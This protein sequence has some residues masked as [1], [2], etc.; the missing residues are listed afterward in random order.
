[1][2]LPVPETFNSHSSQIQTVLEFLKSDQNGLS[3]KAALARL[4]KVG[5]NELA[6][7][8]EIN[9]ARIF[10]RQFYSLMVGILVIAAVLSALF[11]HLIDAIVIAAII[12]VN[13]IMGFIQEYK[14]ERAIQALKKLVEPQVKVY[15]DGVIKV[16][17]PRDLVPGDV[18][19]LEEGDKIPADCRLLQVKNFQTMEASLTGE[20]TPLEKQ[21]EPVAATTSIAEQSN[22]VWMGTTVARGAAEAVVIKTGALTQFGQIATDLGSIDVAENHFEKKTR[23]LTKQMAVMALSLA[24]A[25]FVVGFFIRQFGLEEMLLYTIA[26]LVSALPEGLPIILVIVLA[27]GAQKMAQRNAIV[28]KLSATETLGVVSVIVTDKTGTLTQNKMAARAVA[29]PGSPVMVTDDLPENFTSFSA[30]KMV[31]I[32]SVCH[33]VRELAPASTT[34]S[35]KN[36]AE[37]T[38]LDLIGDP[39]EQA[40]Y[41]FAREFLSN[42]TGSSISVPH[43]LDDLPFVQELRLRASLVELASGKKEYFVVGAP[44]MLVRQCTQLLRDDETFDMTALERNHLSAQ[45]RQMTAKAMRVVALAYQ[46]VSKGVKSIDPDKLDDLI[47]VGFLGL[48]DPPR[49]DVAAAIASARSAGIQV[50]MATG[51]HPQ[52]AQAIAREIGLLGPEDSAKTAVITEAQISKMSDAELKKRLKQL[53]VFARLTPSSK[54]RLAKLLQSR[55]EVV[56]MTGDGVNDAPALKQANIGISMGV[57]GTDVAREASEIVLADDNFASIINAIEEGRTQFRNVRRTSC[58]LVVT[59][60]AQ[61]VA[62]LIA[63]FLGFPLPLLPL[64]ILWLNI[65]TGGVTDVALA[66]EPSHPDILKVPPRVTQENIL[67]RSMMPLLIGLSLVTIII[68]LSVF[69]LSLPHG[70]EYARTSTFVALSLVLLSM[71]FTMRSLHGSIRKVGI[72]ANKVV[73]FVFIFSLALLLIAVYFPPL[74]KVMRFVPLSP[75]VILSLAVWASGVFFLGELIKQIAPVQ[76]RYRRVR[77]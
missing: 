42:P 57:T 3:Q 24:A 49:P 16:E 64:Q 66:V 2:Q 62:L 37:A 5:L 73:W 53:R 29:L 60:V 15:R 52:T 56:A 7:Q 41:N 77:L 58:F 71:M 17:H 47:L 38:K 44:E 23:N 30:E 48:I 50:V 46:P 69:A 74:Q 51:D 55:G 32:S 36:G 18:V 43:K 67:S 33:N 68:I 4:E 8:D 14:A 19:Q 28:R 13:A 76:P 54:F 75:W 6:Q 9:P 70:L 10:F 11:H 45:V 59:S 39:T 31:E 25:T 63:L 1:M 61:S 12:V 35:A 26:T 22:M 27:V 40:I 65:V 72:F 21:I 20:S 34:K